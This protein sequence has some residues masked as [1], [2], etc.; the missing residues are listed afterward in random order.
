MAW[1]VAAW[2]ALATLLVLATL[3][4]ISRRPQWW[5]R[6][7]DFP[8]LQLAT[9]AVLIFLAGLWLLG[10]QLLG[11]SGWAMQVLVLVCLAYQIYWVLPY[12]PLWHREVPRCQSSEAPRLR[13]LSA[14]VL[15]TNRRASDLL[16]LVRSHRPDL[17]I[18]LES[19]AWWGEQLQSLEDDYPWSVRCP[20]D[21]LYGMHLFSR[22]PLRDSHLRYLVEEDVPSIHTLVE[23]PGGRCVRLHVLHPAPPSPSE[24]DEST[25]RD[26]ELMVV[27]RSLG[28]SA[29]PVVVAGDLNDVAWSPTTR[30]FHRISGLL[31]PRIGRGMFNTFHARLPFLRWPLDH[32]FHSRDFSL[33]SLRRLGDIG[34]DHFPLWVE[35]ALQPECDE[36]IPPEE[37]TDQERARA[38]KIIAAGKV[39]VAEVPRPG[40]A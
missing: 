20:L 13:L 25:E 23:L 32:L 1:A 29:E 22:L 11:S 19:D 21:N 37:P 26:A 15:M 18:T 6:G 16:D 27:A 35:L 7:L 24:N 2:L 3:L 36:E 17:L 9:L 34:S 33:V 30:L 38:S 8:R 10:R 5:I 31:D 4:P 28:D 40:R 39:A 12:T 14:N